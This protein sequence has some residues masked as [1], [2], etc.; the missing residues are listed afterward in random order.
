[1]YDLADLASFYPVGE[2]NI[3]GIFP[4]LQFFPPSLLL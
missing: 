2:W 3:L 1:M 4:E